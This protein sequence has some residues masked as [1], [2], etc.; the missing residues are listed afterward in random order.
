MFVFLVSQ[1]KRNRKPYCLPVQYIP[2]YSLKDQYVR[3][4]SGKIKMQMIAM[5]MK[6]IAKNYICMYLLLLK[7][8][9]RLLYF[10]LH[11]LCKCLDIQPS[12]QIRNLTMNFFAVISSL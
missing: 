9:L 6:P 7:I 10:P 8:A 4:L 5:G 11:K 2:Y 12:K 3:D 1:E